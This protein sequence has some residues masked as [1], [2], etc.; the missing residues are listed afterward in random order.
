[1]TKSEYEVPVY[2]FGKW[3]YLSQDD[4]ENLIEDGLRLAAALRDNQDTYTPLNMMWESILDAGMMP[5]VYELT[6]QEHE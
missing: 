2:I 3:I 6:Q 4:I 1:M 5:I